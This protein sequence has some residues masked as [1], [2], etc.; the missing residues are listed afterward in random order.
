MWCSKPGFSVLTLPLPLLFFSL[1]LFS[2]GL[3]FCLLYFALPN[4]YLFKAPQIFW[5]DKLE[6]SSVDK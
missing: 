4:G 6:Y 5:G 2:L 3:D 1:L